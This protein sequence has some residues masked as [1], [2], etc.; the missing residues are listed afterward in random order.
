MISVV[1]PKSNGEI[2]SI[3]L[4][5]LSELDFVLRGTLSGWE[6][7]GLKCLILTMKSGKMGKEKKGISFGRSHTPKLINGLAGY[8]A[9]TK[10]YS[11]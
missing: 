6:I 9:T 7:L 3:G 4:N 11:I 1:I 10:A 5:S 8:G 2:Y